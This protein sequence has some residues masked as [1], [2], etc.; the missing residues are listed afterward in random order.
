VAK[1]RTQQAIAGTPLKVAVERE[2]SSFWPMNI[3]YAFPR[4]CAARSPKLGTKLEEG[5]CDAAAL[6]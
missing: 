3:Q 2:T 1:R 4:T 5:F 6:K